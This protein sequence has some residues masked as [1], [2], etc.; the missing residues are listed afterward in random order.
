MTKHLL[1]YIWFG[2]ARGGYKLNR[3]S[4]RQKSKPTV[5]SA[6]I[7]MGGLDLGLEL[8]EFKTVGCIESEDVVRT[9]L[10][11]N[12]PGWKL[13][14]P[15]DITQIKPH[16]LM[17]QLDL[18]PRQL[19]VLAGGPPCQPF[20]KAAQWSKRGVQGMSDARSKCI[21]SFLDLLRVFLP[22]VL[23][24]E[25]VLGFANG[26][27]SA[28]PIIERALTK[29]NKEF[30]TKYKLLY[31]IIDAADFGVPQHRHRAIMI[32]SREGKDF[33]WPNTTHEGTPVRAWDALANV[34][35]C[36]SLPKSGGKWADLLSSIPEGKNYQWHTK[37][38]GGLPLFGFRTR[39]WSFLLKLAKDQPSWTVPAQPGPATGP[40]HWDNRPLTIQERLRLQSFPRDWNVSGNYRQQAHQIGNATPPLLAEV[41]GR[42]IG[43]QF[44]DLKYT[45]KPKLHIEHQT[46]IPPPEPICEVPQKY[47]HL[48]GEYPPHPGVGKGPQPRRAA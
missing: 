11:A 5:L 26:S 30:G 15:C 43:K 16:T 7:G 32:A 1:V 20:S 34:S 44:F 28:R 4:A 41:V 35:N 27:A 3:M 48:E 12:R 22:K 17:K 9:T 47:R 14:E 38:G 39:F 42:A 19:G 2:I 10:R 31:R 24:I 6:F 8:A 23:L 36:T 46:S 13:L 25:N 21:R 29:I 18:K 40:F 45:G 33:E 37:E